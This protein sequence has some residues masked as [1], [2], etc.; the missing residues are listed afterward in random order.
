MKTP[1]QWIILIL[2]AFGCVNKQAE[3]EEKI[4]VSETQVKKDPIFKHIADFPTINDSTQF[5][6]DLLH[7]FNLEAEES[8]E[9]KANKKV[10]SYKKVKIFGSDKDFFFIACDF[11]DGC[12]VMF[13]WKY[14]FLLTL[15]GKLVKVFS[16][17]RFELIEIFKNEPPF[18]LI[19]NSTSKGNGGHE[20][21]KFSADTLENVYEGYSSGGIQTYDAHE[22]N[23][24]FEPNELD[25][26]IK[27]YNKDGFNDIA[28]VGSKILLHGQTE[29]GVWYDY[30]TTDGKNVH[31]S[32]DHPFQKNPVKYIFLYDKQSGHFKRYPESKD[33]QREPIP[34]IW[35][36][37]C[38]KGVFSSLFDCHRHDCFQIELLH[39]PFKEWVMLTLDFKDTQTCTIIYNRF[40]YSTSDKYLTNKIVVENPFT[41]DSL[42]YQYDPPQNRMVEL[43][44]SELYH[45]FYDAIWRMEKDDGGSNIDPEIWKIKGRLDGKEL[46]IKR[47]LF[48]DSLFYRP[49]QRVLDV[50][51]IKDYRF[52]K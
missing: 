38:E 51:K 20:I 28:F 6:A 34:L 23:Q 47:T 22:D 4:S 12:S 3:K 13:P 17:L 39:E 16:G 9:Q 50:F 19:L 1:L 32:V 44:N 43:N 25:L 10:T 31:Y 26:K 46:S 15:E 45:F 14:Q 2:T 18:L 40:R 48:K 30:K 11:G 42:F 29:R 52:E 49:I 24:I 33:N 35:K 8:T 7:A 21:Y 41:K 36:A 37:A 5:I 27:D